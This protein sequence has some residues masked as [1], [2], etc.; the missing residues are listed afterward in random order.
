MAKVLF[1]IDVIDD[2]HV[3]DVIDGIDSHILKNDETEK[4]QTIK[5][6]VTRLNRM[7]IC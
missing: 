6:Y 3:I 4:T 2:V 5:G 1:A 7:I